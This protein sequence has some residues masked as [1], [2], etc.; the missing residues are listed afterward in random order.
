MEKVK[1][2]PRHVNGASKGGTVHMA[3]RKPSPKFLWCHEHIKSR[4]FKTEDDYNTHMLEDHEA[5]D[6][7]TANDFVPL[8]RTIRC[9]SCT[10]MFQTTKGKENHERL[11]HSQLW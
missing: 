2:R 3:D 7:V 6:K 11:F 9:G 5:L 4:R 8:D 10:A 1:R